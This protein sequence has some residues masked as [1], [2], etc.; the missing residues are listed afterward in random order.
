MIISEMKNA[1]PKLQY[2]VIFIPIPNNIATENDLTP[3]SNQV[4]VICITL[5]DLHR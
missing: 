1:L 2:L 3:T 4:R 5:A